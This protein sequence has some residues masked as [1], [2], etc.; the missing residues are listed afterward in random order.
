MLAP[1]EALAGSSNFAGFDLSVADG[2]GLVAGLTYAGYNVSVR[3]AADLSL[4][5]KTFAASFGSALVAALAL[6]V[7]AGAW[8]S[9]SASSTST[10][11]WVWMLVCVTGGMLVLVAVLMQF[12]L[13]RMQA[14]RAIVIMVSELVFAA[15]SAWWLAGEHPGRREWI[16]AA[17]IISA[18]LLSSRLERSAVQKI[19]A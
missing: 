1:L 5:H 7:S 10:S 13:M 12:A 18:S 8:S 9:W 2:L 15:A 17:L 4:A 3:R 11:A 19:T 14:T 6:P 16:G